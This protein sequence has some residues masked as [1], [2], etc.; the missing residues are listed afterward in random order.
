MRFLRSLPFVGVASVLVACGARHPSSEAESAAPAPAAASAAAPAA[1]HASSQSLQVHAPVADAFDAVLAAVKRERFPVD[2]AS[3]TGGVLQ[4]SWTAADGAGAPERQRLRFEITITAGLCLIRAEAQ[5]RGASGWRARGKLDDAEYATLQRLVGDVQASLAAIAGEGYPPAGSPTP[6]EP[7]TAFEAARRAVE[8]AGLFVE[9]AS[10]AAGRIETSW[11]DAESPALATP[12]SPIYYR[13]RYIVQVSGSSASARA[14]TEKSL[15]ERSWL[16]R[17][18]TTKKED[19]QLEK[20]RK[21]LRDELDA[22]RQRQ[23][24]SE[25]N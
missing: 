14:E 9:H 11:H 2:V 19:A 16:P 23:S 15:D 7:K 6:A 25:P 3:K 4:T 10:E 20:L 13:V 5:D 21:S 12:D 24:S 1:T 22:L 8:D 18:G 17:M